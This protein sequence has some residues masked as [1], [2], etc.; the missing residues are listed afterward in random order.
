MTYRLVGR[1]TYFI[2][3]NGSIETPI[4]TLADEYGG[5]SQIS[6]DDHCWVL[7]NKRLGSTKYAATNHWY[8]EAVEAMRIYPK[9]EIAYKM[10]LLETAKF[11]SSL[12]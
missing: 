6:V 10:G 5:R 7:Y 8:K 9:I 2:T 11:L 3:E 12:D 4:M 1:D